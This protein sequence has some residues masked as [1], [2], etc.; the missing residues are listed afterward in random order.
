[1]KSQESGIYCHVYHIRS[2]QAF[3]CVCGGGEGCFT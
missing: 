2:C 3:V 1:M